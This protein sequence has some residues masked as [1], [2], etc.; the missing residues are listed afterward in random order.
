MVFDRRSP[1]ARHGQHQS[2][3]EEIRQGFRYGGLANL[4]DGRE[5]LLRLRIGAARFAPLDKPPHVMFFGQRAAA[6]PGIVPRRACAGAV[7]GGSLPV[8][9]FRA[10]GVAWRGRAGALVGAAPVTAPHQASAR[11]PRVGA[12]EIA[13]TARHRPEPRAVGAGGRPRF[14]TA[15]DRLRQSYVGPVRTRRSVAGSSEPDRVRR[16]T[17]KW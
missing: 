6:G 17:I 4:L 7:Q 9:S 12:R 1:L 16:C 5:C 11:D 8:L 14:P 10:G 15:S 13:E 3:T 2:S